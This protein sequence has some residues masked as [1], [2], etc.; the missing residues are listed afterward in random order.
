MS[1]YQERRHI[2]QKNL[3]WDANAPQPKFRNRLKK[4]RN[5]K[6]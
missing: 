2:W 5:L 3:L 6:P 4:P 1:N